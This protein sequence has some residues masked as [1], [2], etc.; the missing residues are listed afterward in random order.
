METFKNK[1]FVIGNILHITPKETIELCKDDAILVDV[2]EEFMIG[3][4]RFSVNKVIYAPA[5]IIEEFYLELP[6]DKLLIIADATG[7]HSKEVT[8]FL[9]EKGFKNI[10]NLA[11]G[12]VEWEHDNLPLTTDVEERLTGSCMCQLKRRDKKK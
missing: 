7:I 10:A 6:T 9:T 5:S 11:G 2:R 1:G 12:L 3:Y 8:L 4:K